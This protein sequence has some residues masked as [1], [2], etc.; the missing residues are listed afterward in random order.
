MGLWHEVRLP[1]LG[2]LC[3]GAGPPKSINARGICLSGCTQGMPV[4]PAPKAARSGLL[5]SATCIFWD[6]QTG[7]LNLQS[8]GSPTGLAPFPLGKTLGAD[9]RQR[10]RCNSRSNSTGSL[11]GSS[12]QKAG[13]GRE[14]SSGD[15][16]D[17]HAH[18]Q[19]CRGG[20]HQTLKRSSN[21]LRV[22]GINLLNVSRVLRASRESLLQRNAAQWALNSP[23]W[24]ISTRREHNP[25]QRSYWSL[26]V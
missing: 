8:L 14:K 21:L 18:L 24:G 19:A 17:T 6:Q 1:C 11:Q 23:C 26:E 9:S 16:R 12:G 25:S 20:S 4:V 15:N 22:C 5:M 10:A 7:Y 2:S 3:F 13:A